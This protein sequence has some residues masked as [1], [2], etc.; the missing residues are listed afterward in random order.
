MRCGQEGL[1]WGSVCENRNLMLQVRERVENLEAGSHVIRECHYCPHFCMSLCFPLG[2]KLFQLFPPCYIHTQVLN[3]ADF[4]WGKRKE[5]QNKGFLTFFLV[6]LKF[7]MPLKYW[8]LIC[9]NVGICSLQCAG[10]YIFCSLSSTNVKQNFKQWPL[11]LTQ[12]KLDS[13]VLLNPLF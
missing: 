5:V 11:S 2:V 8:M 10:S 3:V 12:R 1:L 9:L 6:F 4:P 13:Y 7:Q